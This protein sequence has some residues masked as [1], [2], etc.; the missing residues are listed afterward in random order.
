[1]TDTPKPA[2][3][4]QM[5]IDSRF[6]K[7]KVAEELADASTQDVSNET[8]ELL[9]FHG[10]YFGHNRDTATARKK[11]KL[12]KE[13]EFMVRTRIP[14]GQLTAAQYLALDEVA[15]KYANNSLRI[16]TRQ[17]IQFHVIVKENLKASI[18][19]I[20]HSLL[21]TQSACGDV[22]RNVTVSPAPYQDV[23]HQRLREDAALVAE[24][25]KPKTSAYR[26]L[27][28]DED[29]DE[30]RERA[31]SSRDLNGGQE[32]EQGGE[33]ALS[34]SHCEG[35]EAG[36]GDDI[37]YEPLYGQTYL[38]RKFKI[39]LI[40]PEDNSIDVFTHDLGFVAIFEGEVLQGYNVLMGGGMGMSHEPNKAWAEKKTYPAIA[41]PVAF[42]QPDDL[43][44]AV[45]A[46]VKLQRDHGD[47]TDRK[48]ARLKYL[49]KEKGLDWTKAQFDAYFKAAG[50]GGY[51]APRAV[52]K[53]KIPSHMGWFEQ[54][55]GKWF[56]GV[57]V[58]SGRVV[59]YVGEVQSGYTT[60]ENQH[61]AGARYRTGLR[62]VITKYGMNLV[63][64]P[65][66][67]I[68]LCDVEEAD[69]AD[70][71]AMLRAHNISLAED[72]TP[73]QLH[74]MTCVSLPTCAKALAESE[75][76]QFEIMD[77]IQAEMDTHG[78]G[79]ARISVRVTGCPNGCARPYVGDIGI[80]GRMPGHYVLFIGGDFEGTRLNSK[81]FDKVPLAEIPAAL[82]PF[83][84]AYAKDREAEEGFGDFC[85]RL[86]VETL[87][88]QLRPQLAEYKWAVA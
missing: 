66:E 34:P 81:L 10:S 82:A 73:M 33:P 27:W 79:D 8:Y 84:A 15:G 4:E 17:T 9:K 50:G 11:Q 22:V 78:I 31:S 16:T 14:A 67:E 77:G 28:L 24:F 75:R 58:P 72:H 87:A 86:G 25:V 30:V 35:Q 62:E 46:V 13:Y 5:K 26:E 6:L 36:A 52:E 48:H 7:G 42:I 49:V 12:D 29:A 57:P 63:L 55:D 45:E 47:R 3:Q 59:D 70:I 51:T 20:N 43:L 80:V 40:V 85:H 68:I 88:K 19:E 54:G 39:G 38:P 71:E 64:T 18:A 69:K 37:N 23:Q 61:F 60:G 1:M 65:T 56:L 41:E 83:F 74:Y 21:S 32:S 53:Y 2:A 44:R 76:V